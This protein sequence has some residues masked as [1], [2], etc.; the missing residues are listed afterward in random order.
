M[1]VEVQV[2][3]LAFFSLW[4]TKW[5][6]PVEACHAINQTYQ[7]LEQEKSDYEIELLVSLFKKESN[8]V[9]NLGPNRAGA[10]GIGQQIPAYTKYYVDKKYT[11]NEIKNPK[12][13]IY[14]TVKALDYLKQE[15]D[16]QWA[17]PPAKPLTEN[18]LYHVLC[19]YNQGPRSNCK[20]YKGSYHGTRYTRNI[21]RWRDQLKQKKD[22]IYSC[23]MQGDLCELEVDFPESL[24]IDVINNYPY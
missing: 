9:A 19:M 15:S 5:D 23:L 13:S 6:K 20:N 12:V 24:P 7:V 11:C 14:L 3:C 2:L 10:C 22:E 4:P 16:R 21:I 8:F 18:G 17:K 1:P